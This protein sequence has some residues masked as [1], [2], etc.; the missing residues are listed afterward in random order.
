MNHSIFLI[1]FIVFW[2][3]FAVIKEKSDHQHSY[4]ASQTL[5]KDSIMT[6]IRKIRYCMTYE[7]RVVKWRRS[8]LSATITTFLLFT[9]CWQRLPTASEIITHML[10][11]TVVFSIIW[12]NFSTR[13]GTD[14]LRYCDG[15]ISH[16]KKLLRSNRNFILPSW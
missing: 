8:L 9:V 12:S 13:T 10:L 3:A 5:D 4:A 7:L 16:V 15:N 6:S 11:I 2:F 1:I 14:A